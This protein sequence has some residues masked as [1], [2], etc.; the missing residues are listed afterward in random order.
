[1]HPDVSSDFMEGQNTVLKT[2]RVF[3]SIALDQAH[4]QNNTAI[5]SD[6]GAVGLAQLPDALRC[7]MVAAPRD[8]EADS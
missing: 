6:G 8:C 5:K 3:S 2:N 7:W 4:E 1:M